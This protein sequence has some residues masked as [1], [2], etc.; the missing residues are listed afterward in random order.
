MEYAMNALMPCALLLIAMGSSLHEATAT[1]QT[2]LVRLALLMQD[3][4]TE[5][6]STSVAAPPTVH[7]PAQPPQ[8]GIHLSS[9]LC[10]AHCQTVRNRIFADDLC[11]VSCKACHFSSWP[12]VF[13]EV[14]H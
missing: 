11:L 14:L 10:P 13:P 5:V 12:A 8:V 1:T 3:K 6:P 9:A 2:A 7:Q 4:P